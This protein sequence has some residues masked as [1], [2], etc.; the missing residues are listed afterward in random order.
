MRDL[1]GELNGEAL[2]LDP[3]YFDEALIGYAER[4][5]ML[6]AAYSRQKCIEVL[7]KHDEMTYEDAEEHFEFNI[8]GSWVGEHTPIFIT[9]L[10]YDTSPTGSV[11]G[12]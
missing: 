12:D 4:C 9:E 5:G 10:P 7:V 2:F 11:S 3:E 1:I 8:L 6:V